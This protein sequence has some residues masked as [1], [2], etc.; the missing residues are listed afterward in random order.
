MKWKLSYLLGLLIILALLTTS[1][2]SPKVLANGPL[3]GEVMDQAV[4]LFVKNRYESTVLCGGETFRSVG[5]PVG[6]TA[7]QSTSDCR[8]NWPAGA[9]FE[10]RD[11]SVCA[12]G[13]CGEFI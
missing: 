3:N 4:L 7:C 11:K 1:I 6:M 12:C 5:A 9:S 13:L 8:E 2:G 10:F